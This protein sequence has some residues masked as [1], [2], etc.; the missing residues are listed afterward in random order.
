LRILILSQ[1]YLPETGAPQNRLS[2]LACYLQRFGNDVEILTA[3][4]NYPRSQIYPEY[5]NKKRRKEIINNIKVNR[6]F[7]WVSKNKGIFCRL[8]TYFSFVFSSLIHGFFKLQKF[9][10]IICESPPLFLGL[11]ALILKRKWKCKLV[12]N[13]SDLWPESAE[14]LGLIKNR[15]ILKMSYRLEYFIYKNSDLISCQTRGILQTISQTISHTKLF[16]SQNGATIQQLTQHEVSSNNNTHFNLLYAGIIGHAQGLEIILKAAALLQNIPQIQFFIM[17]DG[18]VKEELVLMKAELQLTNVRFIP[19]QPAEK[20]LEWIRKS[21]ACIVPLKKIELFKGAIP[22]KIFESLAAAKPILL[23]VDGEA[24]ELFITEAKGGLYFTPEDADE[25]SACI[26]KLFNDEALTKMLGNN[27]QQYV[28]E[29]FTREQI[30]ARFWSSLKLLNPDL[31]VKEVK[32]K[33]E[34]SYYN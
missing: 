4:P 20:V 26:L 18:P 33:R 21:A 27:G 19:N 16:W 13:V 29:H 2:S 10:I 1:Y 25:L 14:K 7:I 5:K 11:T 31:T 6:S 22:S 8:M 17:G 28:L 30:A 15:F 3:L 9:D 23:G 12:F 24:K 34:K 32:Q